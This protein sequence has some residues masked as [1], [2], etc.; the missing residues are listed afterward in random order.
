MLQTIGAAVAADRTLGGLCDYLMVE[1]AETEPVT[2]DGADVY[3][4][5]TV[6]IVAVYGTTDPL[7]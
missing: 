7:N 6:A 3:R 4:A 2:D 5:A 1:A